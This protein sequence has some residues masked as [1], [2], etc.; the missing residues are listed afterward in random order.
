MVLCSELLQK[1]Q[2]ATARPNWI[3]KD[4]K[5]NLKKPPSFLYEL[6]CIILWEQLSQFEQV[7]IK[8]FRSVYFN[9]L[10]TVI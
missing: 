9:Q 8:K 7:F 5:I 6:L 4:Q 10:F 1:I 2:P 3:A